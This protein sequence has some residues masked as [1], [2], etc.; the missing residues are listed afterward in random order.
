MPDISTI[1]IFGQEYPL[2]MSSI[3][4]FGYFES[5]ALSTDQI[6]NHPERSVRLL[7]EQFEDKTNIN[8]YFKALLSSY[9]ELEQVFQDMKSILDLDTAAGH[10][11][12]IIGEI[13]G[14]ARSNRTDDQYRSAIQLKIIVNGASGEVGPIN[15][16]IESILKPYEIQNLDTFPAGYHVHVKT[17]IQIPDDF[18]ESLKVL[19]LGGV[20]VTGSFAYDDNDDFELSESDLSY[21][22]PNTLGLG[23]VD[24]PDEGG[25]LAEKI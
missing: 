21:T 19:S 5:F 17:P 22:S 10:R 15:T 9:N 12:D 1:S 7:I 11:L 8:E 24:F 13:V 18:I 3:S 23:E 6:T 4:S 14:V 25:M 2:D 16:Y 20:R